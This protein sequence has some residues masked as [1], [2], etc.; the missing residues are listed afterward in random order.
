MVTAIADESLPFGG[1]WTWQ[2]AP[3][4][5]GCALRIT[6]DGFVKPAPFRYISRIMGYDSTIRGYLTDLSRKF[7]EEPKIEP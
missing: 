6:E 1:T 2:L 4:G 3:E 7:G 5:A